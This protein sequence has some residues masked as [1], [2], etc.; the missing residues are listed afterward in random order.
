[1]CIVE[2]EI[3]GSRSVVTACVYPVE[4]ECSVFTNSENITRQRRMV[5]SMLR[6]LAP[7]ST[8]I[9]RLCEEFGAPAYE[10]F[11]TRNGKKCILCGLCARACESLGTGAISTVGRG[12]DKAVSTPYDEPSFVCVGCASCASVCP[13][14][15]IEVTEDAKERRI[16]NK[17]F[18]IK[19]C[20]NCDKT[21]GTYMEH[22]RAAT[23]AGADVPELCEACRKKAITDVMAAT[24]APP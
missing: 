7:E 13:T 23:A 10:R 9:A 20:R 2:V 15:A 8:E 24:Y 1:V 11:T 4:R 18:P 3:E 22:W 21:M 16:W 5:L 14:G 17:T 19:T 6:A 12:V